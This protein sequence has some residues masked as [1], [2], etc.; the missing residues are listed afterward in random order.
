MR[1]LFKGKNCKLSQR[2][3]KI[4]FSYTLKETNP[5]KIAIEYKEMDF[6]IGKAG[7][8]IAAA[9]LCIALFVCE[10]LLGVLHIQPVSSQHGS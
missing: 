3:W 4:R 8:G 10:L 2:I 1:L 6:I 5:Q 9:R 7:Q